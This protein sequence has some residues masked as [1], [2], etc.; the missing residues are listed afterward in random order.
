MLAVSNVREEYVLQ[1]DEDG[2]TVAIQ[3][4]AGAWNMVEKKLTNGELV[5]I[6]Y[7][8]SVKVLVIKAT[9]FCILVIVMHSFCGTLHVTCTRA[10]P[11]TTY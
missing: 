10:P 9:R 7:I 3:S 4:F 2:C 11:T 5:F 6:I 1:E 8:M